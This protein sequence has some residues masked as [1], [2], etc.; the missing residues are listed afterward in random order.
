MLQA[1]SRRWPPL[2]SD[3]SLSFDL[4]LGSVLGVELWPQSEVHNAIEALFFHPGCSSS[5]LFS[6]LRLS[7][8][9]SHLLLLK[10]I[11]PEWC[12]TTMFHCI[13]GIAVS[14]P[15]VLQIPIGPDISENNGLRVLQ[16]PFVK[17][18]SCVLASSTTQAWLVD[19][20][21]DG[22][23]QAKLWLIKTCI[24]SILAMIM[25]LKIVLVPTRGTTAGLWGSHRRLEHVLIFPQ[26]ASIIA[27]G[28]RY[29]QLL[30]FRVWS[31]P[32][33][34]GFL[35]IL[36][37]ISLAG[38]HIFRH[39]WK[40]MDDVLLFQLTFSKI[41]VTHD[42][43]VVT[44][45]ERYLQFKTWQKK[46]KKLICC[47]CCLTLSMNH[48]LRTVTRSK[49]AVPWKVW[50]YFSWTTLRRRG[51]DERNC[52]DK[53]TSEGCCWQPE[54]STDLPERIAVGQEPRLNKQ[55]N[56][57]KRTSVTTSTWS[58]YCLLPHNSRAIF[59]WHGSRNWG[60]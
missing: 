26:A 34:S 55:W 13:D 45:L 30:A 12:C 8:L 35:K 9:L 5:F 27:L 47:L 33:S 7:W 29:L 60:M 18:Q 50:L 1:Y 52:G 11:P 20:C 53:R 15:G 37:M 46:T 28:Q 23:H 58:H 24:L 14:M 32:F 41:T 38:K 39:Q 51:K 16:M 4:C 3:S 6:S 40:E 25:N 44:T 19:D 21:R 49:N 36:D 2:K 59:Y 54:E 57:A 42:I 22:C 48:E 56:T 10:S 43:Q 17:V 31:Q